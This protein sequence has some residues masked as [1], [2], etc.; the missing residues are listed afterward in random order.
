MTDDKN[1]AEDAKMTTMTKNDSAEK[2][3]VPEDEYSQDEPSD[4]NIYMG[5]DSL[6]DA[7]AAYKYTSQAETL[8]RMLSRE[9]VFISGPPGSGKSAVVQEYVKIMKDQFG[10]SVVVSITGTTGFVASSIGGKTIHSWSG[11]GIGTNVRGIPAMVKEADVLII[12][13]IS[14]LPAYYLDL[15]DEVCRRAKRKPKEPFGGIQVI[16]LG[17]FMQLPPVYSKSLDKELDQRFAIFSEAWKNAEV[18]I[19]YLDKIIRSKDPLLTRVLSDI[20]NGTVSQE[21]VDI[22]KRRKLGFVKPDSEKVY[23]RLYTMNKKVDEINAAELAKN[24]NPSRTYHRTIQRK[25][26]TAKEQDQMIKDI[27]TPASLELKEGAKVM[28][29]KNDMYLTVTPKTHTVLGDKYVA[30]GSVG[31]VVKMMAAKDS[32]EYMLKNAVIVKLNSGIHVAIPNTVD[33]KKRVET[34][35][36][37]PEGKLINKEIEIIAVSYTPLKLAYAITVHKSQGQT[38]DGVVTD[39]SKC[40]S[41]GMGYVALS[42]VRS[43]DDMLIEAMDKRAFMVDQD[44]R[45]ISQKL[46]EIATENRKQFLE[47]KDIYETILDAPFSRYVFWQEKMDEV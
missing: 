9:N 40:F 3:K 38:L 17:D 5:Y 44:S 29:T 22:L 19:C 45:R 6:D 39:L 1:G 31:M 7:I 16:F 21:T 14:M 35:G 10:D 18:K 43:L 33:S 32:K 11:V 8:A 12:D 47:E 42:R 37:T 25:G 46:K 2:T 34:V 13:E 41:P 24:P 27:K 26:G 23:T 4:H 30:N 28:I 20:E 36:K 15:V